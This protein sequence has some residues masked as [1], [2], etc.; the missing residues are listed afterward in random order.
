MRK[1][2]ILIAIGIFA[3]L[4]LSGCGP[5][6]N[7]D[8]DPPPVDGTLEDI[9]P[10]E[11][12]EMEVVLKRAKLNPPMVGFTGTYGDKRIVI[13]SIKLPDKNAADEYF[14]L[15]IVPNFDKMK[16]HFRGKINGKWSASGTDETKRK[17][18]GWVNNNWVFLINASDSKFFKMAID[19]FKYVEE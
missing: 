13:N 1:K 14:E 10:A 17:W 2:Q 18:F 4:Y 5:D 11:I 3:I 16:N 6:F 7:T 9:F 19:A 8:F 15:A 12:G